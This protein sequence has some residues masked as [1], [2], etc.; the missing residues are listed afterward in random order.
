MLG[1]SVTLKRPIDI[2]SKLK[3]MM[4]DVGFINVVEKVLK[5]PVNKWPKDEKKKELGSYTNIN[6]VEGVEGFSM[7]FLTIGLR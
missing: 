7:K 4:D 6:L 3:E 2:A 5:W 1:A